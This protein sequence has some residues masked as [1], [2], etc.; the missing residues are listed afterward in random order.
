MS[1]K[2]IEYAVFGIFNETAGTYSGGT[3]LSPVAAYNGNPAR[4]SVKDYGDN[5]VVETD[6][7]V[8]GGTLTVEFNHDQEDIYTMLLGHQLETGESTTKAILFNANDVAPYVGTGAIGKSEGDYVAKFYKKVQFA[9]PNDE[10]QTKQENTTFNHV[11]LEGEI[12][13]LAD[14]SWKETKRFS[15][16]AAAKA[17]LNSKVGLTAEP[18]IGLNATSINLTS[19]DTFQLEA[20]TNQSPAPTI[21][22]ASDTSATA[23]VSNGLVTAETTVGTAVVTASM[24]VGGKTYKAAC[25]VNV[26]AAQA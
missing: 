4:S 15:T 26:A 17:W 21:T 5:R 13:V 12:F 6:N 25:A 24:T 2:G 11:T 23:T 16:L 7:S 22:W 3:Y 14:G 19:G 8:T 9:E 10:N 20:I 1:K 18:T